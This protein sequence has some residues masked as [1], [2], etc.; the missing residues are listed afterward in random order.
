MLWFDA[1]KGN[2]LLSSASDAFPEEPRW[3]YNAIIRGFTS[4]GNK[5]P[6][7]RKNCLQCMYL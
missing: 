5:K 1:M 4:Y 6:F 3:A 2:R 7:R